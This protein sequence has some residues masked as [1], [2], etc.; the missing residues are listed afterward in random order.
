M[1]GFEAWRERLA[2][3]LR[4]A[5]GPKATLAYVNRFRGSAGSSMDWVRDLVELREEDELILALDGEVVEWLILGLAVVDGTLGRRSALCGGG[6]LDEL[7]GVVMSRGC[8]VMFWL[9]E[10]ICVRVD[11]V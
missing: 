2:G 11:V 3:S 8:I 5:F 6:E 7:D 9:G 10:G 4:T 1:L